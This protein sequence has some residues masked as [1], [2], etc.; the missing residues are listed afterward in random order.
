MMVWSLLLDCRERPRA[1]VAR[2]LLG[3]QLSFFGGLFPTSPGD[4][5]DLS[6]T[7]WLG[8]RDMPAPTAAPVA[9]IGNC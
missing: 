5:A 2:V 1:E 7:I 6:I 8:K 9:L 3:G 4:F